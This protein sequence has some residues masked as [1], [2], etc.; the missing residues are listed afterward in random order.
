MFN[1]S[2]SNSGSHTLSWL[3]FWRDI[4][5]SFPHIALWT[6]VLEL[7]R[8][9]VLIFKNNE[10]TFFLFSV[11]TSHMCL[12]SF[13]MI[14]FVFSE[15]QGTLLTR[16]GGYLNDWSTW[17]IAVSVQV[18]F[19]LRQ[20]LMQTNVLIIRSTCCHSS[21]E[22]AHSAPSLFVERSFERRK[23]FLIGNTLFRL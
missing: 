1:L 8:P 10:N 16:L 7:E 12:L 15:Q 3:L 20:L 23:G 4:G 22:T 21:K 19:V 13:I 6:C 14:F 18:N 17:L 9:F 5:I 11:R 2:W